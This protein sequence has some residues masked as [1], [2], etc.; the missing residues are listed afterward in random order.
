MGHTKT[1]LAPSW[2]RLCNEYYPRLMVMLS[3]T[4]DVRTRE[5]NVIITKETIRR[6]RT[7]VFWFFSHAERILSG[8]LEGEGNARLIEKAMRRMFCIVRD[9]GGK[10]GISL[11]NIS[12]NASG[13]GTTAKDRL[14]YLQE[15]KVRGWIEECTPNRFRVLRAPLEL[16]FSKKNKR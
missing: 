3:V 9:H 16:M 2:R 10:D 11:G 15:L 4:N 8:I 12:H 13:S 1:R 6:A 7:L 14:A 5:R